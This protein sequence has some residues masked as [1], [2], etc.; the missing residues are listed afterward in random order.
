MS[1]PNPS[2][3][4]QYWWLSR[5][6]FLSNED[7][8]ISIFLDKTWNLRYVGEP[9]WMKTRT[10]SSAPTRSISSLRRRWI[11]LIHS[12]SNQFTKSETV[13]IQSESSR[14]IIFLDY[15]FNMKITT[16]IRTVFT[17]TTVSLY[18]STL[19]TQRWVL[20]QWESFFAAKMRFFVLFFCCKNEKVFL[21]QW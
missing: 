2:T 11:I 7:H 14:C 21:L 12:N 1:P 6:S 13:N 10:E 5:T 3:P 9:Q 17:S 16:M 18:A 19:E 8:Q 15:L 4:A 20:L